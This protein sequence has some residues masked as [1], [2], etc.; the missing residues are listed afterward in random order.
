VGAAFLR[1]YL[2]E[3]RGRLVPA[4][5]VETRLLLEAHLLEKDLARLGHQIVVRP[6]G[7]HIPLTGILEL[8]EPIE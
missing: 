6:E 5:G 1:S 3:T 4:G 2:D 7:A 8:L